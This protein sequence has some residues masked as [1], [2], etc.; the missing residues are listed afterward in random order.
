MKCSV[1]GIVLLLVVGPLA[2]EALAQDVVNIGLQLTVEPGSLLAVPGTLLNRPS[3][4]LSL[5][6]TL[7]LEGNLTNEGTLQ[8]ATGTLL[9]AGHADQTLQPGTAS[10]GA[11]ELRNDGPEG[12]NRVLLPVDLTIT[13][14]LLLTSGMLRTA[15]DATVFLPAGASIT[16]EA[17]GRY[18]QG[19]LRVTRSA[20]S[21]PVD[22]GNGLAL[23]GTGQVLGEVTVT[24]T[25]GLRTADL[26]Y[27]TRLGG[28]NSGGIDRIWT[29]S[30]QQAPTASVPLTLTWLPDDDNGLTNLSRVRLYR[31]VPGTS[32]W[33]AESE[34][35]SAIDARRV[36]GTATA[37]GRFTVGI[38]NE[39]GTPLPTGLAASGATVLTLQAFPTPLPAGEPLHLRLTTPLAGPATVQV[40]DAMGRQL[41]QRT[42][43][44]R[45]GTT[46]LLLAEAP[47]WAAAMLLVRVQHGQLQRTIKV[48]R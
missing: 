26:S 3:A 29:V 7:H 32:D 39:V 43:L 30:S 24:R 31:Q 10:L 44:L 37:L 13:K 40:L 28:A 4:T 36:Q 20:V 34:P 9:L 14:E 6:G 48:L 23:D 2:S 27:G 47:Q 16:G 18:V 41:L 38:Q 15:A 5:Q 17:A 45:A 8:A 1:I 11:V 22:F 35:Q 33:L 46:T 12:H 42:L 21:G 25:A 19:N